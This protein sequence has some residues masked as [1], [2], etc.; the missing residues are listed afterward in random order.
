MS[1]DAI[2]VTAGRPTNGSANRR[3]DL[4]LELLVAGLVA[5]AILI[6]AAVDDGFG[7]RSAWLY[8]TILASA[9][10]VGKGLATH[11]RR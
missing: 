8:V 1:D 3:P 4:P 7:A 6:A 2:R 5:L 9:W 11:H 10:M